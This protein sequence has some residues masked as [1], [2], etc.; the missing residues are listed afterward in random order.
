MQGCLISV[1][2][3]ELDLQR[4]EFAAAF[5]DPAVVEAIRANAQGVAVSLVL[6]PGADQQ[7][8]VAWTGSIVTDA[9]LEP[10]LRGNDRPSAAALCVR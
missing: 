3:P 2:G 7:R 9:S 1:D 4:G 10:D 5:R 8:A 6:W